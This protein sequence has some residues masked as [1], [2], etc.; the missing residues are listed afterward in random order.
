MFIDNNYKTFNLKFIGKFNQKMCFNYLNYLLNL[1]NP[2]I[3]EKKCNV[4]DIL[5]ELNIYFTKKFIVY[6]FFKI[7]VHYRYLE[8]FQKKNIN[9]KLI[10]K[11]ILKI[12]FMK[13]VINSSLQK[14]IYLILN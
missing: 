3:H 9:I 5:K 6:K 4:L 2:C 8:L 10:L 11:I 7:L 14:Y 13:Y 1:Q 12:S